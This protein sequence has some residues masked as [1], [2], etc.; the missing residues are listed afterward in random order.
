MEKLN[1]IIDG[2]II[3]IYYPKDD[4]G[5]YQIVWDQIPIGF[6]YLTKLEGDLETHGWAATTPHVQ[7]YLKELSEFLASSN[8]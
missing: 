4:T 5:M 3:E 1:F 8:M 2:R 6:M 7:V